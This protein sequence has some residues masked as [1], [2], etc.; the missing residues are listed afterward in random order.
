VIDDG[1]IGAAYEVPG[2]PATYLINAQGRIVERLLGE[3]TE[4][5]LEEQLEVLTR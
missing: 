1:P 4:A 5:S 2:L 3:V